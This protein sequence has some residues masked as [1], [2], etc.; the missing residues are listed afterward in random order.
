M[1]VQL[2]CQSAYAVRFVHEHARVC[3]VCARWV[4]PHEMQSVAWHVRLFHKDMTGPK[5]VGGV[6]GPSNYQHWS[7]LTLQDLHELHHSV[8]LINVR[9]V[10]IPRSL[11][12]ITRFLIWITS[13]RLYRKGKQSRLL[14]RSSQVHQH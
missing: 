1:F 10:I 13:P 5:E 7:F 12:L 2:P 4:G 11:L 8:L 14:L 6:Y 3:L 9:T